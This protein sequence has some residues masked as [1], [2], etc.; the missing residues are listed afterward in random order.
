M[1]LEDIVGNSYGNLKVVERGADYVKPS[2]AKDTRWICACICGNV[3]L[4]RTTS[5]KNGDT[6]SCGCISKQSASE[7]FKKHGM[8]K[9][10]IY[11]V[12]T[13]MKSRCFN[14]NNKRYDDW[15]GRGITVC[16]EWLED[17]EKFIIWAKENGYVEGL[18]IER[19]DNNKNYSPSNCKWATYSE[20]STNKRTAKSNT[21]G[22]VGVHFD[23]RNSVWRA[24]VSYKKKKINIGS[25][26]EKEDAL[27]ARNSYITK[28]SLPHKI[29]ET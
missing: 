5:L 28:N 2:G 9:S 8:S 3:K 11:S 14:K 13:A 15:G 23:V 19:I 12:L 17:S 26:N 16:N 25:F 22:Y 7:R 21:S 18:T 4:I 1:A 24:Q 29:Q 10:K 20:Q 27:K 6:K